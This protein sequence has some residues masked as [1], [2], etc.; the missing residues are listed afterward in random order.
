MRRDKSHTENI[1]LAGLFVC[2][3]H[4]QQCRSR[5]GLYLDLVPPC[6]GIGLVSG[7]IHSGLDHDLVSVFVVLSPTPINTIKNFN[8][9]HCTLINNIWSTG[10]NKGVNKGDLFQRLRLSS[11]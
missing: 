5:T 11:G 8:F 6:L 3:A 10:R 2:V 7:L 4:M 1:M 9:Q